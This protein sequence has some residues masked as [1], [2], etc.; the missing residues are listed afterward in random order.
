MITPAWVRKYDHQVHPPRPKPTDS[1]RASDATNQASSNHVAPSPVRSR[2]V[3]RLSRTPGVK[4]QIHSQTNSG[5]TTI[6]SLLPIPS[7]QAAIAPA[8]HHDR[9]TEL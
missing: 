8:V 4:V 6:T 3:G 2:I 9:R 5:A 1:V 7:A